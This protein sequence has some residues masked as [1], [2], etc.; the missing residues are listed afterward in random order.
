MALVRIYAFPVFL[1]QGLPKGVK[2]NGFFERECVDLT[3]V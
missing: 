1:P 2:C 3:H